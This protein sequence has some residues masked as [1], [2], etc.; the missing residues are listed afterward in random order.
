MTARDI[1]WKTLH[2]N[3]TQE[4]EQLTG[5]YKA[6]FEAMCEAIAAVAQADQCSEIETIAN[7]LITKLEAMTVADHAKAVAAAN[8]YLVDYGLRLIDEQE[9]QPEPPEQPSLSEIDDAYFWRDDRR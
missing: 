9:T 2:A 6:L 8:E 3:P 4:V 1:H 7:V 5:P